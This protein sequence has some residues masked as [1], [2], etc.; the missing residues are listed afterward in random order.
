MIAARASTPPFSAE[1]VQSLITARRRLQRQRAPG[2][3]F[4]SL[5]ENN[6]LDRHS[7][8]TMDEPWAAIVHRIDRTTTAVDGRAASDDWPR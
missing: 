4:F 3:W 7:W 8:A 5:P 1:V 6:V 2:G